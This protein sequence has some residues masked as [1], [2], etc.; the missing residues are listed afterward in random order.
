[1]VWGA[2]VAA[3]NDG[4][5]VSN[6]HTTPS[7]PSPIPSHSGGKSTAKILEPLEIEISW[8]MINHCMSYCKKLTSSAVSDYVVAVAVCH[9]A[10]PHPRIAAA[11]VAF[12]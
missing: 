7:P 9:T 3:E 6:Y 8:T 10:P 2:S 1:M 5:S 4:E 12:W 11:V